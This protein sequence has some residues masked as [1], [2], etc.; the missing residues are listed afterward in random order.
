MGA[1]H[2]TIWG[3]NYLK[4]C[5]NKASKLPENV[6][7]LTQKWFIFYAK[8]Q[9]KT[10]LKSEMISLCRLNIVF[11]CIKTIIKYKFT[12]STS[13]NNFVARWRKKWKISV[14]TC[15]YRTL[16]S[17]LINLFDFFHILF[18]VKWDLTQTKIKIENIFIIFFFCYFF[19][20]DLIESPMRTT[21]L[22]SQNSFSHIKSLILLWLVESENFSFI[23]SL[24]SVISSLN[25]HT[26]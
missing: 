16:K 14:S 20:L 6:Q 12:I 25:L 26:F 23:L 1:P 5:K 22:F 7:Q 8:R 18:C 17:Y 11:F 15:C 10:T 13:I 3:T 2:K 24:K 4:E 21:L 9:K 19:C